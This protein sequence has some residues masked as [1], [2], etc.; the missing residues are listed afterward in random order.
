M[1][2]KQ[3][4][5]SEETLPMIEAI[6]DHMPGGFFIYRA[7]GREEVLYV[8]QAVLEIFGCADKEEFEALTGGCFKGMLHPDDYSSVSNAIAAQVEENGGKLDYVEYRIIR[9]DKTVRWVDDYGH[10]TE[11]EAYGGIFYVFLSDIT[12]KRQRM[13][14]DMAVR[15]AVIEALSESYHTVWLIND[16]KM[17]NFSLYRGDTQG[18]TTH[19]APIRDALQQMR[20]SKAKEYYIRTTVAPCDRERLDKELELSCIASRLEEK[21]QYTVN[22]LRT[23]EDGSERYFRIEFAKVNMPGGRMGVVCGFKDVDD[24]VREG[25]AIQKALQEAKRAEEE[26][27]ILQE[28]VESAAKLADFLGSVASIL[29]NMPAMSFSKDAS[30]GAYV[31]CNQAF[32]DYAHK[33]SP[34][35]VIG[36]TDY[37]LFDPVTAAHFAEDDRKA[38]SMDEPYIFFEDVP[39]AVGNPRNFQTTKSKFTDDTG[40]LCTLGMCVDVTEMTRK[41]AAETEARVKQQELEQR[42]ILQEQLLEQERQKDQQSQMIT[43]MAADYRCVYYVVLDSDE[44]ICYRTDNCF[45]G[46]VKFGETFAFRESFTNYANRFVAED[47]REEFLNFIDSDTIREKLEKDLIISYRYLVIRDGKESYEMLRMAG[48]RHPEDRDDHIVHAIGVGFT[49]IDAEMRETLARN[50]ALSDALAAAEEANKAKTAFLSNMSHEIRTPMNA[51]IGLNNIAL[52]DPGLTDK[53]RE[54]LQKIGA[55]ANHL[56]SIINDILDMSRIESGR[57][58]IRNEEFSFSKLL[59]QVNTIISGQ[60]RDKG[61]SYECHMKGKIDDYYIGDDMKLRQIMINILGNAV[62]FT[63]AGGSVTFAVEEGQRF[64][65]MAVLRF[66]MTDTGIG[67]SPEYLPKIFD[68]FSQ[69]NSSSSNKYGST[70]LGMPITK[71]LVELMNGTID[72]ASR[73]GEGTTFTVTVTLAESQRKADVEEENALQ[74]HTMNVLVIDDDPVACEHAQIVLGHLGIRCDTAVSGEEALEMVRVHVAR[75]EPY[76]LILV[77]W[78]MPGMDGLETTRQIRRIVGQDAAIIIL[79]SYS[80][81][82]IEEPAKEAGVDS[83]APKPLFAATVMDEFR[84]AFKKKNAALMARKVDLT[85][86]RILL[87]EDMVINAEIMMMIL[88]MRKMETDLAENGKIALDMFASH[89][90]GHYDAILMDMRMPVM[91]GLEATREIRALARSDAK[92]IPIIAL[93]A[94]AFD[95]DVQRSMQAGLNAHLSK[96]VEPETLFETLERLIR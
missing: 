30:T 26:K 20:Y 72:V 65:G 86:R 15:M 38:L 77:D 63:P 42:L 90:E 78:K 71:S 89:P 21:A 36:L 64:D 73:K 31:A 12:E 41:K 27:R 47:Y 93:T 70:G 80:W 79:T 67:M 85:G 52:N 50:Q 45:E 34:E 14:E 76:N 35:G 19:A 96:P 25:Q 87:A 29:T 57:M 75:M 58:S 84:E 44:G 5:L 81:E 74:P 22:Y 92:T 46:S 3:L 43:A 88:G 24:D 10:Y 2:G 94:N 82:D 53:T 56:L 68:T 83:F 48:V 9:K 61:L 11:T 7:S 23:M 39:D 8:N 91:D 55:S 13:E 6:G 40:R 54:Y 1:S 66:T 17:E 4:E 62:K 95:E 60:C 32:A 51:I 49:D 59:E 37:D 69:E 18:L 28:K 33:E 16:V